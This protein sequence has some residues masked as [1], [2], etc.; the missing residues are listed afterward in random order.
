VRLESLS[1]GVVVVVLAAACT[2]G[3]AA[4]ASVPASTP[5]P[6]VLTELAAWVK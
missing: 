5:R 4:G 1:V 6:Q 3:G 2:G